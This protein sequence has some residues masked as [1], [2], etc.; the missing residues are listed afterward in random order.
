MIFA[1][2]ASEPPRYRR[3]VWCEL[4]ITTWPLESRNARVGWSGMSSFV[5]FWADQ[6][7]T[8]TSGP[9]ARTAGSP[10]V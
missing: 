7:K 6:S 3:T 8:R 2:V 1:T 9:P 4:I 5:H 10:K